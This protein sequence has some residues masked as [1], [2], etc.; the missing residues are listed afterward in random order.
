MN[1]SLFLS[2]LSDILTRRKVSAAE[3]A[4]KYG[5]SE[6][7]VYRYVK[8]LA[9]VLPLSVKKGRNGGI[10]LSDTYRLPVGFLSNEEFELLQTALEIAYATTPDER[11]LQVKRKIA[12]EEKAQA[13][14]SLFLGDLEELAV[15][16][17]GLSVNPA[18]AE[19][20]RV[21][22]ECISKRYVTEILYLPRG[23]KE[24]LLK[25]EPHVLVLSQGVWQAYAFCHSLRKFQAFALGKILFAKKTD[26]RFQRRQFDAS[27]I[28][29]P[30]RET[31]ALSL[32]LALDPASTDKARALF[33]AECVRERG[34]V[35]VA[36]FSLPNDEFLPARLV[37]LERLGK[38]EGSSLARERLLET[39]RKII[40]K[41]RE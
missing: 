11:F 22:Q 41:Y 36:E 8:Q 25:I 28:L 33:G 5:V 2:L 21:F 30:S 3:L 1:S 29:P 19:K 34:G 16:D 4:E 35:P 14:E 31:P 27:D 17:E 38:I 20:L 24:V 10:V 7:T 12:S 40:E 15:A 26:D 6:R 37:E 32:R 39:A 23:G 9:L 13:R 18:L